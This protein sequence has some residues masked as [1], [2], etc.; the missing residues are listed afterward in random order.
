[1]CEQVKS[2]P[3]ENILYLIRNFAQFRMKITKTSR[4]YNAIGNLLEKNYNRPIL[5]TFV[6]LCFVASIFPCPE[7]QLITD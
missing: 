1:M 3:T 6:E 2:L 4:N 7:Y 5:I